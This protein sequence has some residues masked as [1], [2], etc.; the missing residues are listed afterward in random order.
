MISDIRKDAEVRMDK[1][2]EAFKTQISK[3]RTGRASPSLLDG[4]V[5]EYYGTPT[6][7]RQLA[8]V[9]VEDSRTLKINVFDRS[10]S[11]AV[12]KAIMASDLGLNPNSAGSDIRV[13]LP[14]LTE[15]R[16]KDLT[17][18]V[19]GEAEQARVAVRN[20]RRDAND[21][22]KALLKDKEI[23]E[24]DDRRSQDDVQKLTDAA[25]KKIEAALADKEAELSFAAGGFVLASH[26]MLLQDIFDK[27]LQNISD[28]TL[29]ATLKNTINTAVQQRTT[30]GLVGLAVA[31]Y[32]GINWMGNL[33]EAIRAQSRDVWERS[34]Q[35]Q[36]KFW[37]KYLRDFISLIGLLIALIVT[38]SITSVAGSAQQM[39]IS[40][41]HLNSIEWLKPTWRLI[42][43]AISI[44]ANYLLFFWIF[45][46]LPR[47]RPRKKALIRG[48][49]LAAI[50]FEVIKIVM[51][52]T[53]PSL[54]KSPSGAAFG[55]VLG[56]MAFFYFFARLTLFCA[57][58]I[59]TAEYKDDPRMPGKTQP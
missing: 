30:V 11:P 17:K 32:S 46:R 7:L 47:H 19:R 22:V 13:P 12:E 28:P 26:P 55:S 34:P 56:L 39:I 43:L 23:S 49:F 57:A 4:I 21:K 25:I 58:W 14:P 41:L 33:R 9:T 35:D 16:R 31:L 15:E 40:A 5:V 37:V 29:A 2:V 3:I 54:M 1:C 45:W 50:G 38:L 18:I 20:V 52:Y 24:D 59:A 51:T 8:S 36:E 44:F 27:I 48:T 6:P 10:M 53:L 42:G